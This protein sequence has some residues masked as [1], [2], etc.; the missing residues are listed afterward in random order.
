MSLFSAAVMEH[1][2]RDF[3]RVR[4]HLRESLLTYVTG[5]FPFQ[6][7][8]RI[9]IPLKPSYFKILQVAGVLPPGKC[10][11]CPHEILPLCRLRMATFS[12]AMQCLR[13]FFTRYRTSAKLASGSPVCTFGRSRPAADAARE[14]AERW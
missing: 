11:I 4:A 5:Q 1:H 10:K 7:L 13:C 2:P 12:S 8:S 9:A 6:I 3:P 14:V